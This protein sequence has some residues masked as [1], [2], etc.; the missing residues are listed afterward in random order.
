M[1]VHVGTPLGRVAS[2]DIIVLTAHL[3]HLTTLI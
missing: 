3:D 1:Y 2:T